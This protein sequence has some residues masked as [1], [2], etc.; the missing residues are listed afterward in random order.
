MT[1]AEPR[2][3]LGFR[4]R[5]LGFVA[6]LLLG[7]AVTGLL[8]QRAVL[9]QQLDRDVAG[10]LDQE[11]EELEVLAAGRDP[12]TGEPFDGDVRA[13]FDTHLR[14][15]VPNEGEVYLTFVDGE[16][17]ATTPSPTDYRLDEQPELV[18][19]WAGITKGERG[20]IDTPAGPVEYLAVPL[21]RGDATSGVFVVANFMGEERDEIDASIRTEIVISA[22]VLVVA[23]AAAWMIAGRLLA[24]VKQ[25]TETARSI[26]DTDLSG[27]IPVEGH[28]EIAQLTTT[29][30]A[31]LDRLEEAFDAQRAFVADAGHELRT[32]ITIVRGHLE[33]MGD[34]PDDRAETVAIVTDELERMTRLVEDLLLLAKAE[35]P[36]FLHEEP[37]VLSHLTADVL[38][39]AGPLGDRGWRLDASD[40]ATFDA[41]PQRLTQAWLNLARNAVEHT[42]PG[43]EIGIG[44][45][46]ADGQ[47]RLWVR[48]TGAGI[49]PADRDRIFERFA[50]GATGPR[51]TEGAGLGLSIVR[52]IA[53]AHGGTIELESTPG[54]GSTFTIVL[55]LDEPA[56]PDPDDVPT[57]EEPTAR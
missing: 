56:A 37:V 44:S 47:V 21:R 14:Q 57:T 18:A 30:N 12:A 22:L 55:P 10:E 45:S 16:P 15:N 32:P 5:V 17:Y 19:A 50:R 3:R 49:D 1:T 48:D 53:A 20:R 52:A 31:M 34:D 28:D 8:L 24:P 54:E 46:I 39:K 29:F 26:T 23:I 36:D 9:I 41:D 25:L 11:R 38:A 6:L 51:R 42:A 40:D 2:L 7:S 33:L 4:V 43:D 27:R 35:Q 13:I